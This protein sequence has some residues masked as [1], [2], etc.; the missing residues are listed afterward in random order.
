MLIRISNLWDN[1]S[2]TFKRYVYDIRESEKTI[3]GRFSGSA[4][5][6]KDGKW[7]S[8]TMSFVCFKKD[9]D[10]VTQNALTS[11]NGDLIEIS[12]DLS[13]E[14]GS[15]EKAYFKFIIKEARRFKKK[16][17][18]PSFHEIQEDDQHNDF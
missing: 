11:H 6:Q 5:S 9:T 10:E 13:V 17:P 1:G 8:V 12:G 4:K 16:E 15:D 7:K 18:V 14:I 3:S 2:R